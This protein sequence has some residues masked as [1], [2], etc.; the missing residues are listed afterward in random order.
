MDEVGV[1]ICYGGV[2][3]MRCVG[4]GSLDRERTEHV[5]CTENISF[6]VVSSCHESLVQ[7]VVANIHLLTCNIVA[8]VHS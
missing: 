1:G 2:V 3:E 7:I 6:P 4:A 8:N 5:T